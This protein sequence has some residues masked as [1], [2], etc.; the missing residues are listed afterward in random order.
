[1]LGKHQ[2]NAF[3]ILLKHIGDFEYGGFRPIAFGL[4]SLEK[5][6]YIVHIW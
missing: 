5:R 3:K 1:M 6:F 4:F 2:F